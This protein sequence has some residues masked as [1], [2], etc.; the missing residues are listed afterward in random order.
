MKKFDG[1]TYEEYKLY[2]KKRR[3]K[4]IIATTFDKCFKEYRK[5]HDFADVPMVNGFISSDSANNPYMYECT[6]G[7]G[8]IEDG[9]IY[10]TSNYYTINFYSGIKGVTIY[11]ALE[12]SIHYKCFT[13][14]ESPD[15]FGYNFLVQDVVCMKS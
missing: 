11:K 2:A 15:P 9:K 8:F 4:S 12:Q 6:L 10:M 5:K 13:C 14:G 3:S 7:D 1:K